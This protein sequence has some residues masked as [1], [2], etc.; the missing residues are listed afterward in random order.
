MTET[1]A[2]ISKTIPSNAKLYLPKKINDLLD[3][4]AKENENEW[5]AIGRVEKISDTQY[6]LLDLIFPK[7]I[8]SRGL[9][10]AESGAHG[11]SLLKAD[12]KG[13]NASEMY[14]W[15]H[16]HNTM[17]VFW[18]STDYEQMKAMGKNY[19]DRADADVEPWYL[20]FGVCLVVNARGEKKAS[21]NVYKPIETY[22]D[23][24]VLIEGN[25]IFYD[26]LEARGFLN[27]YLEFEK[28]STDSQKVTNDNYQKELK[29]VET[30]PTYNTN[31]LYNQHYNFSKKNTKQGHLG[32]T[33]GNNWAV[34]WEEDED[35]VEASR[36]LNTDKSASKKKISVLDTINRFIEEED[37]VFFDWSEEELDEFIT[38][39]IGIIEDL[40][41]YDGYCISDQESMDDEVRTLADEYSAIKRIA[42]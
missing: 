13:Y 25:S 11:E 9:T 35:L 28:S 1:A 33:A 24:E 14:A 30:I 6:R 8:N 3:H 23:M 22:Y 17:G 19:K 31:S 18:S 26:Y 36:I 38:Y 4:L 16:S 27:D 32:F 10:T 7:Q 2:A 29:S 5:T 34:N 42:M 12:D 21:F 40:Q 20:D 39:A 41:S 15:V 37:N